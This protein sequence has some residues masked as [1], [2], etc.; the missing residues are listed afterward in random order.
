MWNNNTILDEAFGFVSKV[1]ILICTA[2]RLVDHL[3][4]TEG[5]DLS[6]L[7]FLVI[8]EADR[9]LDGVQ[10]DWLYHLEKHINSE[11]NY[12]LY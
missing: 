12:L 6:S 1:D 9:V 11:G 8:D 4:S 3:K 10:H 7:E 2:G 5:F